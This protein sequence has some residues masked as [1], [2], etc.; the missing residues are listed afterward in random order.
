MTLK[1]DLYNV[2][3]VLVYLRVY[4][5][6]SCGCEWLGLGVWSACIDVYE[7][8]FV[9]VY[10]VLQLSE[11]NSVIQATTMYLEDTAVVCVCI[12][13]VLLITSYAPAAPNICKPMRVDLHCL[14]LS[15]DSQHDPQGRSTR[16]GKDRYVLCLVILSCECVQPFIPEV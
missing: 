4:V 6:Q 10:R 15:P 8:H 16:C 5:L 7:C 9:W 12:L 2:L 3:G 11:N 1:A 13:N 14:V